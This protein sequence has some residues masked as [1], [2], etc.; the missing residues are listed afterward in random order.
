MISF[1][2]IFTASGITILYKVE[3]GKP[4]NLWSFLDVFRV[5]LWLYLSVFYAASSLVLFAVGRLAPGE[6]AAAHPCDDDPVELENT[7]TL[8]NCFWH[9]VGQLFC[10]GS[11]IAPR[12][13]HCPNLDVFVATGRLF[14]SQVSQRSCDA[15]RLVLPHPDHHEL[16]HRR[17]LRLPH[18]RG[19]ED[20]HQV[21]GGS[22]R[23]SRDRLRYAKKMERKK[24]LLATMDSII[25]FFHRHVRRGN[26]KRLLSGL[27]FF[28]EATVDATKCVIP[29]CRN[30]TCPTLR[31]C[32]SA[33]RR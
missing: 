13:V 25:L 3:E 22:R 28:L 32:F 4:P 20:Q 6:W 5:E 24:N 19:N 26:N 11:D 14:F 23:T 27:S 1:L 15:R 30:Q 2:N 7:L 29:F 33:W 18:D 12:Y 17:P 10:Q 31:K 21:G 9:N 16:L 8:A